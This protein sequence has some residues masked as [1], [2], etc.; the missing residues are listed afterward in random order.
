M[1]VCIQLD[2]DNIFWHFTK[3]TGKFYPGLTNISY[4]KTTI[5]A[6]DPN[7][8]V[9]YDGVEHRASFAVVPRVHNRSIAADEDP[10]EALQAHVALVIEVS[11]VQARVGL[12]RGSSIYFP[13]I[14][15]GDFR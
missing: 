7:L 13:L 15:L 10:A 4:T 1:S 5:A 9:L 14:L 12:H 3:I 2:S 8:A 6:C 11:R